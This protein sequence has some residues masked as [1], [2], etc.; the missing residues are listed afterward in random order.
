MKNIH[1]AADLL[2]NTIVEPGATFSLND[3]IGP[4]TAERGLR[5]RTG[6]LRRVHR[7]CRRRSEPARDDDVQR[8]LLRWLRGRVPQAAH[9]LHHALPDGTRSH[10]ELPHR[11]LEVPQQ[12]EGGCPDPDFVQ[13][14]LDHRDLLRRQG[15]QDGD[16]GRAQGPRR[17]PDRGALLRLPRPVRP[18]QGQP[19]R[20]PRRR[21]SP[22]SP[23]PV[24]AAS[25]SSSTE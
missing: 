19:V 8:G 10:G 17:A 9:D 16:R 7:R 4:R 2:N 22:G 15:G 6:L 14:H 25:T 5:R 3:T 12:L 21:A 11:R 24:T 18:R 13:R 23:R 1:R 20:R